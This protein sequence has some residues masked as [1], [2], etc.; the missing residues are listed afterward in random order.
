MA[1]PSVTR[2]VKKAERLFTVLNLLNERETVTAGEL[3][4][5]CHTSVRTIRR[6]MALLESV[7]VYYVVEGKFGYRLIQG[8]R[9]PTRKLSQE[10]WLALTVYPLVTNEIISS[11]H[12]VHH[13]YKSGLEKM[14]GL[15]REAATPQ[16][17]SLS[18]E[19]G[20][21]IRIHDQAGEKDTHQVM[22]LLF[23]AIAENREIEIDYYAIYRDTTSTRI[24]HPYYILPR[25]GHLYVTAYCTKREDFRIF[26]LN[27]FRTVKLLEKT[28]EIAP[29]FNL[30]EYLANRWTIFADDEEETTFRVRF[31]KDIARYVHEFTFYAKTD[32]VIEEDGSVLLEATLKSRKEFLRWV[33]GFGLDAEVLEPEDVRKELR[34]E[35]QKQMQRYT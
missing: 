2:D 10:E 26:R 15:T 12:P 4:E 14:K 20:E 16:L 7:G 35:F 34:E 19:L 8:P 22:P 33:R 32:V 3:A 1:Q 11:E 9:A 18:E 21:R 23:Q 5:Y 13:A 17:L 31:H 28:F 6:D 29:T 30:D 25:S 24:I 27:R